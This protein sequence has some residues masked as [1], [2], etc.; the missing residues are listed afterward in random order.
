M[1]RSILLVVAATVSALSLGTAQAGEIKASDFYYGLGLGYSKANAGALTDSNGAALTGLLGY[2]VNQYVGFEADL[3]LTGGFKHSA[4]D[5]GT[6][7]TAVSVVGHY[8]V[9]NALN[10]YAKIGTS[11]STV[12]YSCTGC[13]TVLNANANSLLFGIGVEAKGDNGMSYRFGLNHFGVDTEISP[14][15]TVNNFDLTVLKTF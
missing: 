7:T 6:T 14:S 9:A 4:V 5:A 2:N 1:K 3:I 10:A 11:S 13:T 12:S 15:L 8:P